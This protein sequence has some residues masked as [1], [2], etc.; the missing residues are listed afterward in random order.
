MGSTGTVI[1]V[2]LA[3]GISGPGL[4]AGAPVP[5]PLF[6]AGARVRVT[7]GPG[8]GRRA[9]GRVLQ[10]DGNT[11]VLTVDHGRRPPLRIE[12]LSVRQIEIPSGQ[13]R[14]PGRGAL[15]GALALGIPLALLATYSCGMAGLGWEPGDSPPT[16]AAG[17]AGVGLA[18]GTALGA[19]VGSVVRTD[20][21]QRVPLPEARVSVIPQRGG[22]IGVALSFRF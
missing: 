8:E 19:A 2:T 10:D 15:V 18:T 9:T 12:W 6:E 14:N 21:W 20:R 1:A 22:G 3:V 16:S 11:L 4:A 5:Q 13:R 7:W 17:C